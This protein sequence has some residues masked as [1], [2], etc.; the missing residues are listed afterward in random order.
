[1]RIH[2]L[3][4]A[5][6]LFLLPGVVSAQE[7]I[8]GWEGGPSN[9]YGFAMPVFSIPMGDTNFLVVRPSGSY[10]YYNFR[11][12]GGFTTVSS[13]GA[14]LGLAYRYRTK[15]LTLTIGPGFEA[16]ADHRVHPDGTS[17]NSTQAGARADGDIYFQVDSL[18]S[19]SMIE[20]MPRPI[21]S[22]GTGPA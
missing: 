8:T 19:L 11:E 10:L 17:V 2:W 6:V 15:R 4:A 16:R 14:S 12:A 9:G 21:T 18:T 1:M 20:A 13:P 3:V 7:L 22:L 5:S